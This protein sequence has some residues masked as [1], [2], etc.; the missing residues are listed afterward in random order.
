MRLAGRFLGNRLQNSRQFNNISRVCILNRF[1][2]LQALTP[3][4]HASQATTDRV[5]DGVDCAI[6][7]LSRQGRFWCV[8]GHFYPEL[9]CGEVLPT[10][11]SVV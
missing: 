1:N 4:R 9:F 3:A 6:I 8:A 11:I 10:K 7:Q 2:P 5:I